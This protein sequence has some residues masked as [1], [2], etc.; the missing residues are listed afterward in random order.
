MLFITSANEIMFLNTFTSFFQQ[1]LKEME[2]LLGCWKSFLLPLSSDPEL[3]NQAQHLCKT[4][5]AKGVTCSE[6]MLKVCGV[7]FVCFYSDSL[8]LMD[9]GASTADLP[10]WLDLKSSWSRNSKTNK[11]WTGDFSF[12]CCCL[13]LLCCLRKK[14]K[15]LLLEFLHTGMRSVASLSIQLFPGPQIE[16]SPVVMLF[17]SW[18]RLVVTSL[19]NPVV[20]LVHTY[21]EIFESQI[22]L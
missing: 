7:Y 22:D 17:W 19:S 11:H 1:L 8:H 6:E 9:S 16:T 5:S 21:I 13:H 18:T 14:C 3:S 4:L 2:G 15:D 10:F 20:W 12:R